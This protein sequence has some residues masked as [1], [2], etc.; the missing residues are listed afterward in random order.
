MYLFDAT[1]SSES[2]I[3]SVPF[4]TAG[5]LTSGIRS[6]RSESL[7]C[8]DKHF[9]PRHDPRLPPRFDVDP[10]TSHCERSTSGLPMLN[11]SWASSSLESPNSKPSS[12][13]CWERSGVRR[14]EFMCDERQRGGRAVGVAHMSLAPQWTS[15]QSAFMS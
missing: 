7:R 6:G 5:V 9:L 3:V 2:L 14:T 4:S 13:W 1:G 11:A 8:N 10:L 12:M 15:A